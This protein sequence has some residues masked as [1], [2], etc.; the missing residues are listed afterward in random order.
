[1][2]LYDEPREA[3]TEE[4]KKIVSVLACC[5]WVQLVIGILRLVLFFDIFSSLFELLAAL[6]LYLGYTRLDF[7][8]MLFYIFYD[9]VHL[10]Y[11]FISLFMMMYAES[12]VENSD[13][14]L[15]FFM[16]TCIF[17]IFVIY[18]AWKAYKVFRAYYEADMLLQRAAGFGGGGGFYRQRP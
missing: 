11:D 2:C 7:C 17:Y 10:I 1:M 18:W 9:I 5:M 13:L 3:R 14:Y 6:I 16:F 4:G 15:Y 12:P 8:S